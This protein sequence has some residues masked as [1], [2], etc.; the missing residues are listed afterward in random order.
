LGDV[1]VSAV[2]GRRNVCGNVRDG[3]WQAGAEASGSNIRKSELIDLITW[4]GVVRSWLIERRRNY[5]KNSDDLGQI[6]SVA[7]LVN[8]RPSGGNSVILA[9][10]NILGAN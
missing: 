1:R 10:R 6:C 3:S 7:T 4:V 8:S 5:I 9:T 2:L